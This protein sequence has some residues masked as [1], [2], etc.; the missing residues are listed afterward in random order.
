MYFFVPILSTTS[1]SRAG[2]M[3]PKGQTSSYR[4]LQSTVIAQNLV[5]Y[6]DVT[7]TTIPNFHIS[8]LSIYT[9]QGMIILSLHHS[10][11]DNLHPLQGSNIDQP[12]ISLLGASRNPV[13]T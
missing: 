10:P 13:E 5:K 8:S 7:P 12:R 4:C 1:H 2:V 9:I 6:Y 11:L 3:I